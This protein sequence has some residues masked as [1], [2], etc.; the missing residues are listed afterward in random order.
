MK[1][2]NDL[3][4]GAVK[5]NK[6]DSFSIKISI[7]LAV[8]LLGTV[9]FIFNAMRTEQ[10]NYVKKNVGDYHVSISEIDEK[11]YDKLINDEDI[12]KISFN[13]IIE[14][15]LNATI[16][17]FGDSTG[18]IGFD[19][20]EGRK[21][22]NSNEI[23]VPE[24]FLIKS[25]EY[26]LGSE[27][28]VRD[29]TYKVVGVYDDYSKSFEESMLIGL[30]E[31]DDK[32]GLFEKNDEIEAQIWY[33]NIRD[34]YTK[35][36]EVLSE[37][38]IEENHALDI[39]RVFYNKDILEYK[40][41]YPKGIIP[42]KSVV[43][44]A[45][46]K[47]GA[48]FF[49]CLLFAFIIY[50][51]FNVWNNR[52]L[53]EIA[54]LKSTGMTDKQVK[55]MIR[56]KAFK[57]STLP[58]ALGTIL[59]LAFANLL[60][61]LMWLNNSISYKNMSEILGESLK[62]PGFYFVY[63]NPISII[64]IILLSILTVYLSAIIPARKSAKIKIIEGL[65]G[66][67]E[68]N[69]KLGK[70]KINGSIEKTLAKDYYR[71]YRSTYRIIV[72]SMVLSAFVLTTVLVSQSYRALNEKYNSYKSPYNFNSSIYTDKNLDEN[73]LA[74]LEK[75]DGIKE[76]HLYQ[77]NDT[78][79]YLDDNKDFISK[80]LKNSL[81]SGKIAKDRLYASLYALTDEDFEKILK[82][83]NIPNAS[84]LLLNK[85]RKD[86][87]T[88]Y[89]FSEYIKISDKDT[90]KVTLK[91]NAE[92]KPINLKID[93]SIEE[94]PYDLEAYNNN[95]I[96][97]YTS[98][99]NMKKFISEYGIDKSDPVY[100]YFVKIK[101]DNNKEKVFEDAEKVISN[102]V[103]KSDHGTATEI[104]R[105]AVSKEQ[106]R[107][108]RLLNLA[109]QII[110]ITIALSN[111]YN[112]FKGNLR[113]RSNDFKLL[114]TAGMKEKQMEKMVFGEGKILFKN[115]FLAYIFMFIIGI[116]LRAYRSNYELAFAIKGL[117]TNMNY[118][119]LIIVFVFM[120]AGVLVAIKSGLKT[121]NENS[122]N[123]FKSI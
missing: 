81:D 24:K 47:Y 41:V 123:T 110:L 106:T 72:I 64:M 95:E 13:K 29:K 38:N 66:I 30:T 58:I 101:A 19:I 105:E 5:N 52:D 17:E 83:N 45:I 86:S 62:S 78:K 37:M 8:I 76:L 26:D 96:P 35:T 118:I 85:I 65:N 119:P 57:L 69:I 50:G 107:N 15:D 56:K 28:T 91:Y 49:L 14:T 18:L 20:K 25:K 67:T 63:P 60:L 68:K 59:S 6:K 108:E 120:I 27:I 77:R 22:N 103:P 87:R 16:Y 99:S 34:T 114:S 93:A 33:K 46:E 115:I 94:I 12:E 84:Y 79:F 44:L 43:N 2:I 97:I 36:R 100:Y 42:P 73:L 21:P 121:I 40:M 116:A 117:I 80:D 112:S 48:G 39:G 53:K 122:D 102:Y 61:Y 92:G 71:S 51:S 82:E 23:L 90:G 104:L 4:D 31:S 9:I 88:P 7:L 1:I 89:A 70:S 113:A 32:K 111:A 74:D 3:A 55:K 11:L 10:Y 98:T 75:V 54:L 109:I